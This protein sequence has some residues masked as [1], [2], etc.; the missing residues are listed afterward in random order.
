MARVLF[1]RCVLPAALSLHRHRSRCSVAAATG[2]CAWHECILV[3]ARDPAVLLL[4]EPPPAGF[5]SV[6]QEGCNCWPKLSRS[7]CLFRSDREP[8]DSDLVKARE[9]LEFSGRQCRDALTPVQISWPT[10]NH[11]VS[12]AS[13]K[14]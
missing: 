14:S 10:L 7:G 11:Q 3:R 12:D 8:R 6:R 9:S 4:D 5:G 1:T 13:R 2:A